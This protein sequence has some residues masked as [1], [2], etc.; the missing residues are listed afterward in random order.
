[1]V[2]WQAGLLTGRTKVADEPEAIVFV[3]DDDDDVRRAL[4]RLIESVGLNVESFASAQEFLQRSAPSGPACIVL[5]VRMPGLSGL[6][7]QQK[8]ADSGM[9]VPIIFMTGHGTVPMTV[10]AMKAGAVDFMEKP[11]DEQ[12]M[13]D[14]IQQAIERDRQSKKEQLRLLETRQRLETLTP[15]ERE[16][17]TLVVRGLLNKQIAAEL[18]ASEKTIKVHRARVMQK[19]Q[20]DSLAELVRMAEKVGVESSPE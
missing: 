8:L 15:R 9:D 18:G 7:L 5:D 19:M 11:F 1:V 4:A 2:G 12:V 13:L 17:L 14:A 3:V 16:V 10:R 20:A 6:D